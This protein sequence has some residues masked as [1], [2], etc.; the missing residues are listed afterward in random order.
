MPTADRHKPQYPSIESAFLRENGGRYV[1][2][3]WRSAP[4]YESGGQEF[5]SL[6]ARESHQRLI[7]NRTLSLPASGNLTGNSKPGLDPEH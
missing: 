3:C 4:D 7:P 6:R 2:S 5:E 1:V